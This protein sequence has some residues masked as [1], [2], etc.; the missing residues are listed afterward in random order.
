MSNFQFWKKNSEEI[1]GEIPK[2]S[3]GEISERFLEGIADELI[4]RIFEAITE[5]ISQSTL[6]EIFEAISR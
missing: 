5:E 1:P 4:V 2:E 3:L 6:G